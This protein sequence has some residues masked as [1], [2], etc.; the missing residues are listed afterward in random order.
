M[1][2]GAIA[3]IEIRGLRFR[4]RGGFSLAIDDLVLQ[5]GQVTA[6][7]GP[8][9]AGKT[10]L[11]RLLAGLLAPAE[12]TLVSGGR[13]LA[14]LVRSGRLLLFLDTFPPAS[15]LHPLRWMDLLGSLRGRR[16]GRDEALAW[17]EEHG[18]G[19]V[20]RRPF[21]KMSSGQRRRAI[22]AVLAWGD[23]AVVLLDEPLV[24][25]DP[26]AV[27]EWR[28]RIAR[29]AAGGRVVLV[30]SHILSELE[31]VAS[32]Y[33]FMESG[34]ITGT[35]TREELAGRRLYRIVVRASRERAVALLGERRVEE[36]EDHGADRVVLLVSPGAG[37]TVASL[38][39]V[40]EQEG[41]EVEEISASRGLAE[42]AYRDA[43]GEAGEASA[44]GEDL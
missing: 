27:A 21:S 14:D 34:R 38:A 22:L 5:P 29:L 16:P 31:L 23:P 3:P 4:Y 17:L 33:V 19:D 30:S 2:T 12:G 43:M 40:F 15:S 41:I 37:D 25:L 39:A 9:G 8:N 18:A 7:V 10:T 28:E 26:R 6:L 11:L 13:P 44:P 32:T 20:A 42:R 36:A 1:T 35:R 24:N